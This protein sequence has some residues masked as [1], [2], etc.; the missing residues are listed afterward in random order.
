[1]QTT[2]WKPWLPRLSAFAVALLLA[3]S[4]VFWLL[5]WP[6]ADAGGALAVPLATDD[7]PAASASDMQR[8]LGGTQAPADA[9]PAPEASSRFQLVGVVAL[10]AGKGAALLSVDGKPARSYRI[11]STVDAGW[12]L[13]SVQPR[14]VA[15]GADANGPVQLR[16][17]LPQRQPAQ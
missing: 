6:A 7:V 1:M 16:L 12:V 9:V 13:Q 8:L 5:R 2:P 10:G 4:L 3:A 11:G 15:M 14:S 17:E